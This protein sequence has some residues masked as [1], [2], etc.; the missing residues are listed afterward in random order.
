MLFRSGAINTISPG[1]ITSRNAVG[2]AVTGYLVEVERL[3]M[4]EMDQWRRQYP[5]AFEKDY[6]PASG[7]RFDAWIEGGDE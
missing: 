1:N 6:D 5:E 4:E 7:L 2:N 3:S